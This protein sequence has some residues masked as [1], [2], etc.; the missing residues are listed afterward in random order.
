MI[1]S[2]IRRQLAAYDLTHRERS[3]TIAG[4]GECKILVA[5]LESE[6]HPDLAIYK[7]APNTDESDV[8]ATW[9]PEVVIEV[10]SPG[11]ELRDYVEKREEY[12]LFGVFE[13]WIVDAKL[14]QVA[15]SIADT[16]AGRP[17]PPDDAKSPP[18][19][20]AVLSTS[21]RSLEQLLQLAVAL[22]MLPSWL[23]PE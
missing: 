10:V 1:C 14:Q 11:S 4:S 18:K 5:S 19:L 17:K 8:W 13:Y 9:I 12:L 16:R 2:A 22:T 21:P 15:R 20:L 3:H 23:A 7:T 6:R